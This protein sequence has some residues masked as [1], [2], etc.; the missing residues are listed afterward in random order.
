[1]SLPIPDK[2]KRI[3]SFDEVMK[4][5][6]QPPKVPSYDEVMGND[7]SKKKDS[8]DGLSAPSDGESNGTTLTTPPPKEIATPAPRIKP[9][10]DFIDIEKPSPFATR[11]NTYMQKPITEVDK[12]EAENK[13]QLHQKDVRDAIDNTTERRLKSKGIQTTKGSALFNEEKSKVK[14]A[15]D[16]G[17]AVFHKY[18]DKKT[19]QETAG[20]DKTIGWWEGLSKGWNESTQG[21][22][23]AHNFINNMSDADR[24]A[25]L[26]QT[27]QEAPRND[28]YMGE[29]GGKLGGVGEF[30]GENAPF[31]GKAAAGTAIGAGLTLAAPETAGASLAGLPAVAAFAMT[32]PDMVNQGGMNE[33]IRRYQILKQEQ[34]EA[35][36]VD[37]MRQARESGI[38]A[39][40]VAGAATN[41]LLMGEGGNIL[42]APLEEET[43]N[44]IGKFIK[45]NLQS[46]V[47]MGVTTGA[48][49][50]AEQA[51]GNLEGI[52]TSPNDIIKN[53][54]QSFKDNATIGS[55]LH[56]IT[57][58]IT[59]AVNLPK[60]V[61]SSFKYGLKDV[62]PTVIKDALQSNEESGN[63]PQGTTEKVLTDIDQYKNALNKTAGGLTPESEASI[64]GLIQAK[65]K[66][67]EE[68]GT[69]DASQHPIYK[70]KIEALDNQIADIQRTNKPLQ[71]EIDETGNTLEKPTFDNI[72]QR[73]VNV[74]ADKISKGKEIE[75]DIVDV[76]TQQQFPE[77]VDKAL[78]RILKEEKGKNKDKENPNT[79]LSDNIEK[80]LS[81]KQKAEVSNIPN[82]SQEV[83]VETQNETTKEGTQEPSIS[84][85]ETKG[86]STNEPPPETGGEAEELPFGKEETTGIAH[87]SQMVRAHD[88]KSL[89]PERGEGVTAEEAVNYGQV[90]LKN[91]GD[92][93]KAASDFKDDPSKNISYDALS[94]VRAKHAELVK[95][96]NRISDKFGEDSK[97]A[98]EALKTETDFYNNTVK[99]MQTEW[100]KIGMAQQ[101]ETDIDTGSFVGM[102]RAFAAE[103]NGK[104]FTASQAKTAK[105]HAKKVSELTKQVEDLKAKLTEHI[106]KAV[107][108]EAA[109]KTGKSIKE[110]AKS[111]ADAI[112]KGKLSRPDSFS[113]ATPASL[114]WDGAIEAAAKTVEVA[115]DIGQGI[116]DGIKY[117]KDSDWYKEL[118]ETKQKEAE[119]DFSQHMK[120]NFQ[121]KDL[122]TRFADKKDS[123][124]TNEEVKAIWEYAKKEYLDKGKS[125][126]EMLHGTSV[127]LGL[128]TKQVRDAITQPK[129]A[130]PI[131]DAMYKMQSR[132]TDAINQAKIFIKKAN[133]PKIYRFLKVIPN[134]FFGL[135]V[136]GHGT[137]GAITH[138]GMNIFQ[139]S[140][141]AKYFPF[142]IKQFKYAFGKTAEYEKAMEDLRNDKDFTFWQR[143]G[144]AVD[145]KSKYDDYQGSGNALGKFFKR[146]SIA[147]DRGFNAL[148][149][150]RLSLAK[151]FY[152]GLSDSQKADPDTAKEIAK[153]VNHATGTTEVNVHP[154]WNTVFFAPKL[155]I[156]RW[157]GLIT[158]PAKAIKTFTSWGKATPAEKVAAIRVAK[159]SGEKIA[160]YATL[161]AINQGILIAS[162]SKQ[163]VNFTN[164]LDN[165]WLK[166]KTN[167]KTIDVSGGIESTMRFI[168][169][170]FNEVNLAYT[171]TKKELREKPG[172]KNSKTIGTQA[173][174]KLSPFM[175]T[176]VDWAIGSDA[177][178]RPVPGSKVKPKKGDSPHSIWS[179]LGEQEL[180]IPVSEGIKETVNSM[181]DSGMSEPQIRDY[182]K[183]I[184]TGLISGGTGVKIA[185]IKKEGK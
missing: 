68:M 34:P 20:L 174:Y 65:D 151:S 64:A 98:K 19:G 91:G 134:F 51:E 165:D 168:A 172:D 132:R 84:V 105:E 88:T 39:G 59:G 177:M 114:V 126:E 153:L 158:D 28:G 118:S 113:V 146:L 95:E 15:Y 110:K 139:P 31:L 173:R 53:S 142:F 36:E 156:S 48:V 109:P 159:N 35:N 82:P 149:V 97:E 89:P 63:L 155:E 99:P 123:N 76:K 47:K 164:P 120:D 52:K 10:S 54:V 112:R 4:D 21:N 8:S 148:K 70:Q 73:R 121:N 101:G 3:P 117:I 116:A 23:D 45:R 37:L 13:N 79:E 6:Y 180:P 136:F 184:I 41:A 81:Q 108:E 74:L 67:T 167:D 119:R 181:K 57:S 7:N 144:L 71:H 94:L 50:G 90:L 102:K 49:T 77:E 56:G 127:D 107:K 2:K 106:D 143:A 124:F 131:T 152:D 29:V 14:K 170:L 176:V 72:A 160:T 87:G 46:A 24:V 125:Y 62:D 33:T 26:K 1:M 61:L 147:G 140:R 22:E 166:F 138:A 154:A 40:G 80:Y 111:V 133:T 137:V 75:D 42:K 115:G 128:N 129:G 27:K 175:S 44:T 100:S 169:S 55:L 163:R 178:G 5:D 162:G 96:T 85:T 161:L 16:N 78:N 18:I 157:Q 58:A 17:D 30:I 86:G 104:D 130:K 179:Y 25:Y 69:K 145:P 43:K 38:A 66:I 122:L 83:K 171:G 135:K 183:G 60:S 11:D 92:A 150:Y 185:D 32:L 141:W 103:T 9:L 12:Q 93:D 182:L